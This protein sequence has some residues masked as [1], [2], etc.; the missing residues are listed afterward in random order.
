[1]GIIKNPI[2]RIHKIENATIAIKNLKDKMNLKVELG[3]EGIIF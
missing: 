2:S 3:P 1:M